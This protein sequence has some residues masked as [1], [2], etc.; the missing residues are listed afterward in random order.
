MDLQDY[1]PEVIESM[2]KQY[3][4]PAIVDLS[5]EGMTG[6]GNGILA[7]NCILGQNFSDENICSGGF[8]AYFDCTSGNS[9]TNSCSTGSSP[10][11]SGVICRD[12][13]SATGR[14]CMTGTSVSGFNAIC[15]G[16]TTGIATTADCNSGNS[17]NLCTNGSSNQG[18]FS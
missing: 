6:F 11:D 14:Q 15:L 7:S 13:T 17:A 12:G 10:Y 18:P 4:R 8:G 16:G 3:V 2:K 5:I 9:P 1:L